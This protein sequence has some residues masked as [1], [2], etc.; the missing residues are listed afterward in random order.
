M[1]RYLP[2]LLALLLFTSC[3]SFFEKESV[4]P[5]NPE[6]PELPPARDRR[7][8]VDSIQYH[9]DYWSRKSTQQAD[10]ICLTIFS[11]S[12]DSEWHFTPTLEEPLYN[13]S[14][15]SSEDPVFAQIYTDTLLVRTPCYVDDDNRIILG[16]SLYS[17]QQITQQTLAEIDRTGEE[18][19]IPPHTETTRISKIPIKN[20]GREIPT[21]DKPI[22]QLAQIEFLFR[23]TKTPN[24]IPMSVATIAEK[25]AS[26]SV[27]GIFS[28]NK[29]TT[30]APWRSD[31]PKSPWRVFAINAP[32]CFQIG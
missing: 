17:F 25:N 4:L 9:F 32:N 5:H 3:D 21:S 15:F 18:T 1:T 22:S 13:C 30:G 28:L 6:R 24:G 27:A 2:A 14:C 10:E 16:D 26:S 20:V 19:I 12:L 8:V 23:A 31:M 11:N 29:S 7:F